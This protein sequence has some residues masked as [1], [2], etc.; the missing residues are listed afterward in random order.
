M[1]VTARLVEVAPPNVAPPTALS[2]P[3]MV[4]EPVTERTEVV[5]LKVEMP[6]KCEVEDALMELVKRMAVEVEF[7]L[8]PKVLAPE[9]NHAPMESVP[10]VT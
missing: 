1:P 6:A 8:R 10:G 7:A 3:A 2:W 5:A 9:V 4:E